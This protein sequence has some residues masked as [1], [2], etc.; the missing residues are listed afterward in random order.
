MEVARRLS[1]VGECGLMQAPE[2]LSEKEREL[3]EAACRLLG[4][5]TTLGDFAIYSDN[6]DDGWHNTDHDRTA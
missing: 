1:A 2:H 5:L 4:E 3:W 6:G